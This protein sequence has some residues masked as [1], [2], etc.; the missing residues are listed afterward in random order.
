MK[1]KLLTSL[2][3]IASGAIAVLAFSPFGYWP[4]VIPSLLG[5]YALLD[6]ATPKQAA[7][8]GFGYAMGLFLPG[9]W[10]IHVSMTEFGGIPL[11]A[12]FVLLA[13]LCAYLSLYPTLACWLFARFFVGRHWSRWLLAFPALWLMADWLR[14]WVMT[15]YPWL[16][17]GY[18]Q[19]D[20]P[21]KGFAPLLGVQGITLALLLTASAL[22]LVWQHRKPA[23]LLLP[24]ALVGAAQ[25]LMQLNWVTRGEPV[26]VALVQGNIEQSLKWDPEALVPTVRKYQDLSRENQDADIIV[27]PE[28]AIPAIEKEMGSYLESLDK[29]MKVNDT[30]L[31]AGIIH[32]DLKQQRFFNTVLGMGVQDAEGKES[33]Y[34]EHKNRYYKYHLLPIGEFVPFEDL[35]RPIAPFFNLPMSSFSRGDEVQ[36]NLIAKGLKFAAAICYEIIF[37]DEVRRNVQP[38]TDFLLTVSND[39]WFGTSI[40]PWQHMEIARMRALELAR[41]LLRDT[42]TGI[43]IVTEIDGSIIAQIPQF[44][45]GVLRTEVRP[46]HGVTPYLRFGSWPMYGLAA[47]LLGLA[48]WLRPRAHPWARKG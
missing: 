34:Y 36:P 44:E 48:L 20:G 13:G 28:S 46:A 3:A 40:G 14:G 42:N 7:W 4:M 5:L 45:A 16:W 41:P 6:K 19:I 2:F 15:G 25:G 27:W 18:T 32:Y 17:F 21:L 12:A 11:P 10:W 24:V 8:R 29:A 47:A 35:L 43:T 30:G 39:A 33:Y 22:W 38:D 23:W 1:S 26:K 31:L 37:P 9:Q